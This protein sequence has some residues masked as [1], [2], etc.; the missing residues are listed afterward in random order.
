[1]WV[2]D[3]VLGAAGWGRFIPRQV[4]VPKTHLGGMNSGSFPSMHPR[5]ASNKTAFPIVSVQLGMMQTNHW[6]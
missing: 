4:F 5:G 6:S 1:M 2:S 3:L